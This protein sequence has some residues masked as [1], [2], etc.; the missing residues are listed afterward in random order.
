M[1]LAN[2][3]CPTELGEVSGPILRLPPGSAA[4]TKR[5]P[6]GCTAPR[7]LLSHARGAFKATSL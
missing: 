1:S 7:S 3:I 4:R 6:D 2:R 5:P